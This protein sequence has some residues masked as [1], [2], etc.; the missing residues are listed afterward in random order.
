MSKL[1]KLRAEAG[2]TQKELADAVGVN[3]RTVQYWEAGNVLPS[4]QA[5]QNLQQVLSP[6][7]IAAFQPARRGPRGRPRRTELSVSAAA[8]QPRDHS[9]KE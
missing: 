6:Q 5:I 2:M 3:I 1:G 9:T 8:S 7:V 4:F